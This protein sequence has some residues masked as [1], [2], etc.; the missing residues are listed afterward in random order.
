MI[1]GTEF[2][3]VEVKCGERIFNCHKLILSAR[4]P[5]FKAMFQA[6]MK[7]KET[8]EVEIEEIKSEAV[9]ELLHFIYAGSLSSSTTMDEIAED[10]LGAANQYQLDLLKGICEDKLCS[11][12]NIGNSIR[13]MVVGDLYQA[14]KLR[15]IA[16]KLVAKNMD[17]IV[18]SEVRLT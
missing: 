17:T 7:E 15:K 12:L 6:D 5:V 3:D 14:T 2:S 11:M 8:K 10:L 4:S 1:I 9:A 18:N 13:Y 16:L